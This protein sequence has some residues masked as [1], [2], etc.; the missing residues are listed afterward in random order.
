M[1]KHDISS[2]NELSQKAKNDLE[3]F[4]QS[5]DEDIGLANP[6][7]SV[8]F[9][10]GNLICP[11]HFSEPTTRGDYT[12][13]L[14]EIGVHGDYVTTVSRLEKVKKPE[15]NLLVMKSIIDAGHD[16]SFVFIGDGSMKT[17][18][19]EMCKELGLENK[20]YFAGNRTQEWIAKVLPGASLV[21]SPQM[22][23]GLTEACLAGVPIVAYDY[24]WQGEIIQT[25]ETG[26]LVPDGDWKEMALRA[27]YLLD[28][29]GLAEKLGKQARDVSMKMMSPETLTTIEVKS[30]E[31]LL[32]I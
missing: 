22:G 27:K 8:V 17:E 30:Y 26:E 2:L 7:Q 5:V 15:Q 9:R 3:W 10:Y 25:G 32:N 14:A 20:V 6:D 19:E 28:N 1:Q 29:R 11:L 23:R 21:L 16:I 18:L 4:W 12:S 24:D 31:K 13:L